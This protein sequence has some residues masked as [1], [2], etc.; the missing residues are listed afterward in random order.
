LFSSTA[1]GGTGTGTGIGG[2]GATTPSTTT[3]GGAFIPGVGS[4]M[5]TPFIVLGRFVADGA[6][7]LV[8]DFS[9]STSPVKKSITGTYTVNDDCTGTARIADSTG[10]ARS[11]SFV[12]VN[13]AAACSSNALQSGAR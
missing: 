1:A 7:N 6:G 9:A 3:T 11:I 4:P 13:E 10:L 8:T 2:T 12:L 5:G